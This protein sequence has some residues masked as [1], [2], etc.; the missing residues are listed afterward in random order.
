MRAFIGDEIVSNGHA[1]FDNGQVRDGFILHLEQ[2]LDRMYQGAKS[3]KMDSNMP[4][5]RE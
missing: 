2:H 5:T 1:L 4:H 3:T